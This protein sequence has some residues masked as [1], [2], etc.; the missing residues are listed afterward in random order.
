MGEINRETARIWSERRRLG[1]ELQMERSKMLKQKIAM[2]NNLILCEHMKLEKLLT[3]FATNS[4]NRI[5]S[6]IVVSIVTKREDYFIQKAF[7]IRYG[8]QS[9]MKGRS[10]VKQNDSNLV[11]N[12]GKETS[13]LSDIV[14]LD[15][16]N[17]LVNS[18]ERNLEPNDVFIMDSPNIEPSAEDDIESIEDD[19]NDKTDDEIA[20][21]NQE[22]SNDVAEE[23]RKRFAVGFSLFMGD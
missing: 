12:I 10:C 1:H 23:Q 20:I 8:E 14:P 7:N 5:Q 9:S 15:N 22:R 4:K 19:I 6:K 21:F 3:Y 17:I 2:M 11:E 16:E 18:V 13:H